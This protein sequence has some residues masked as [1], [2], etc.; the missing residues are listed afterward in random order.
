MKN[1]LNRI[2]NFT[3]FKNLF[4]LCFIG[5]NGQ[6]ENKLKEGVYDNGAVIIGLNS[7]KL[8]SGV[9]NLQEKDHC[10]LFFYGNTNNN[11]ISIYNPVDGK[12]SS[13]YITYLENEIIIKSDLVLFPCQ[14]ILD[15]YTGESF[16]F[17]S[18][19]EFNNCLFGLVKSEKSFLYSE[20][21]FLT[22]KKSYLIK[23]DI[24]IVYEKKDEWVKIKYFTNKNVFFWIKA[25][26]LILPQSF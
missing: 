3:I 18:K 10:K 13:G 1:Y 5:C 12:I 22:P 26:D 8:F 24:V 16:S 4:L 19:S 23:N 6:I 7:D 11:H 17:S 14:K 2:N 15:L 20:P 9:M 25:D 21:T